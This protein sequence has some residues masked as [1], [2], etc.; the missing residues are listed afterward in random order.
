VVV[1]TVAAD[2]V[3][4]SGVAIDLYAMV[5]IRRTVISDDVS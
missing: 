5:N 1:N 4:E 3:V 2:R